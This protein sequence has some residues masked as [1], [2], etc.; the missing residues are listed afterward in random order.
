MVDEFKPENLGYWMYHQ[1]KDWSQELSDGSAY[2]HIFRK[3]GLQLALSGEHAKIDV[4]RRTKVISVKSCEID[5]TA[6]KE[7][8][9]ETT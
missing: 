6:R 2:L 1:V 3:T 7:P 4:A 9:Q 8:A 5:F